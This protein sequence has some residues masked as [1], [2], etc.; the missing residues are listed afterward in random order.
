MKITVVSNR[1]N[2]PVVIEGSPETKADLEKLLSKNNIDYSKLAFVLKENRTTLDLPDAAVP[3][4]DFI[5]FL[6]TKHIKSGTAAKKPVKKVVKKAVAKKV[7]KKTPAKKAPAKKAPIKKVTPKEPAISS[8]KEEELMKEF[9][10]VDS[11][12]K[13]L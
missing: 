2:K 9:R 12:Y 4:K 11:K 1:L 7:V 13:S 8:K 5:L 10:D 6:A 3:Q